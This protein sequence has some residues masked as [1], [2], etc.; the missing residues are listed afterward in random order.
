VQATASAGDLVGSPIT[1]SILE[2]LEMPDCN[3][4]GETKI[5][6]SIAGTDLTDST[7][8]LESVLGAQWFRVQ[9]G[10]DPIQMEFTSPAMPGI[11]LGIAHG[12]F[13]GSSWSPLRGNFYCFDSGDALVTSTTEGVTVVKWRV[14]SVSDGPDCS[15]PRLPVNLRGCKNL[16]PTL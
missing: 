2:D 5:T 15:E 16:N 10:R 8:D 13:L 14:D 6:G 7:H 9:G 1:G 3:G 11:A 4:N 12:V